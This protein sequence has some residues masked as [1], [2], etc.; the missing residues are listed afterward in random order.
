MGAENCKV[1]VVALELLEGVSVN[2]GKV[3]VIVL[4]ADKAA[5]IL[6]EGS[7]LVFERLR[8]ADEL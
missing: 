4:L 5:G 6:A 7:D 2:N 8:I 3:V 1:G